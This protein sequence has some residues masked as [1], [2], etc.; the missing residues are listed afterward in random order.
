MST[1]AGTVTQTA[2]PAIPPGFEFLGYGEFTAAT[3]TAIAVTNMTS[4]PSTATVELRN[5]DGTL[6]GRGSIDLP[7][8]GER[9]L[10]LD[11]VPGM[12]LAAPFQGV[13]RVSSVAQVAVTTLRTRINER[14]DFLINATPSAVVTDSVSSSITELFFPQL[15]F[16]GGAETQF[17]LINPKVGEAA[18]GSLNFLAPNGQPLPVMVP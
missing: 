10:F 9:A 5:L 1:G 7:A 2:I 11:E 15:V 14:G 8:S 12:T 16:G 6:R 18:S 4:G 13:V 17:I 3:R